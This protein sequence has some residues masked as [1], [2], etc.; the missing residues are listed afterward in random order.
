MPVGGWSQRDLT[1][2]FSRLEVESRVFP[3]PHRAPVTGR[4]QRSIGYA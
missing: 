4:D 1:L 3:H 2:I